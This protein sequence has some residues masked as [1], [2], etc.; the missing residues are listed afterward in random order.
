MEAGLFFFVQKNV[1]LNRQASLC[2]D[3]INPLSHRWRG[4]PVARLFRAHVKELVPGTLE[5]PATYRRNKFFPL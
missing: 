1:Y 4:K 5:V 3:I 2:I